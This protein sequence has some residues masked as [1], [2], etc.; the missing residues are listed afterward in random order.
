MAAGAQKRASQGSKTSRATYA[1]LALAWVAIVCLG[2]SAWKQAAG[3]GISGTDEAQLQQW[4]EYPDDVT[5]GKSSKTKSRS[6]LRR[7]GKDER[8]KK[9]EGKSATSS[10]SQQLEGVQSLP[11]P[12]PTLRAVP[13]V[14]QAKGVHQV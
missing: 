12:V 1:L 11:C 3:T 9:E 2:Y 4:E 5:Y 14:S 10:S 7:P 13:R 6:K 8:M